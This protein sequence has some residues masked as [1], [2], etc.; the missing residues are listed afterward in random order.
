[1]SHYS[2]HIHAMMNAARKASRALVRDFGEVENLQVSEKAPKDFVSAADLRSEKILMEE[3]QKSYPDYGFLIEESGEV[4]G[5]SEE[6]RWIIDPLDGTTNFI[7]GLPY[8]C[9]SMALEKVVL[10]SKRTEIVAA[11]TSVPCMQEIFWAEKGAGAWLE[12][13][14]HGRQRLRVS[15]RRKLGSA[16]AITGS[17][18]RKNPEYIQK[19]GVLMEELAGVRCIG[20]SA[21][22]LANVAAGRGDIFFQKGTMPWD[23]A[24]GVLL[25]REAGGFVSSF[26]GKSEVMPEGNIIA[27]NDMLQPAML[28]LLA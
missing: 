23:I 26:T 15:G 16:L 20:S 6:Y 7:H 22:A 11:L 17:L 13:E 18:R 28:K 10:G 12:D 19:I 25:I 9:I 24:A 4:K 14:H 27:S 21:L 1:M 3:L 8:F 2:P 5:K